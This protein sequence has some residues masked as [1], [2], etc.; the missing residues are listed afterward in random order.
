MTT[1][2]STNPFATA[3]VRP[4]ALPYLFEEDASHELLIADLRSSGWWGQI[5]GPHGS[6][7]S[8]LLA[9]LLPL[10]EE[11]GRQPVCFTLHE[12]QRS[13]PPA[14][15]ENTCW[16]NH[17]QV[18]VDGYEQLGWLA[19]WRLKLTC[20]CRRAGLLVTAHKNVGLP[21][22]WQTATSDE[23]AWQLVSQLMNIS[24]TTLGEA[25]I[26]RADVI[27]CRHRHGENLREAL[28][29]LYDLYEHRAG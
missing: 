7:K 13:L 29:E 12:G 21:K 14:A 10:L 5:V 4:G 9:T 3:F 24:P 15:S 23:L 20:R 16:N 28:F 27:A 26:T 19:R 8:T 1:T 25:V 2:D 6:G 11:A 17:T 18:I 22:L